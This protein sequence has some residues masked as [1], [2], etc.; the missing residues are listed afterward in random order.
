MEILHVSEALFDCLPPLRLETF[1]V[2]RDRGLRRAVSYVMRTWHG[3]ERQSD[4]LMEGV[5]TTHAAS[6]L[7]HRIMEQRTRERRQLEAE[8]CDRAF[9][10]VV[11]SMVRG[12]KPEETEKLSP[13]LWTGCHCAHPQCDGRIHEDVFER[14]W[15]RDD[16]DESIEM[17][18]EMDTPVESTEIVFKTRRGKRVRKSTATPRGRMLQRMQYAESDSAPVGDS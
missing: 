9:G 4:E 15:Y 5:R 7:H 10:A 13:R 18:I 3:T 2:A 17:A 6:A 12:E 11:S 8:Y 14:H 16:V 1:R